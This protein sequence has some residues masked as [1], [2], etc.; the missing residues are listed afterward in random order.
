MNMY[1][2]FV[3]ISLVTCK[4]YSLDNLK[5]EWDEIKTEPLTWCDQTNTEEDLESDTEEEDLEVETKKSRHRL[6][7]QLSAAKSRNKKKAFLTVLAQTFSKDPHYIKTLRES[8]PQAFIDAEL[9]GTKY[10]DATREQRCTKFQAVSR[11]RRYYATQII[12]KKF[13]TL[14]DDQK[15]LL[16]VIIEQQTKNL[17]QKYLED[18]VNKPKLK[19]RRKNL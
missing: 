5:L 6:S 10:P 4:I 11:A 19:G 12:R 3:F 7:N 9:A 16:T 8:T 13:D 17:F 1:F 14:P 2:L 15:K 18:N